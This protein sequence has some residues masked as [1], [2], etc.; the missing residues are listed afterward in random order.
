MQSVEVILNLFSENPDMYDRVAVVSFYPYILYKVC[1]G[2][3]GAY[4][5]ARNINRGKIMIM[6][7]YVTFPNF[8]I[9]KFATFELIQPNGNIEQ[10]Y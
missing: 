2:T 1:N 8:C 7:H 3:H 5:L 4:V 10:H 6:K 9:I